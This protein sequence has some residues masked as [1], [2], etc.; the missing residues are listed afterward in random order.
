MYFPQ[1]HI[2]N[3]FAIQIYRPYNLKFLNFL[4]IQITLKSGPHF[5]RNC[6]FFCLFESP[7]KMIKNIFHFILKALFV[8][9]ILQFLSWLFS[10]KNDMIRKIRLNS[11]FTTSQTGLQTIAIHILLNIK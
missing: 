2:H 7:L 10:S 11:K 1:L 5:L 9:K 4:S 6:G 8:R 3:I